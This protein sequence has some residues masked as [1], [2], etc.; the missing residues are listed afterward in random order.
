MK[1]KVKDIEA[2]PYRD[3]DSYAIDRERIEGLKDSIGKDEFWGG[4]PI[5]PHPTKQGKYQTGCGHHRLLS[6]KEN[7]VT[8]IEIT[9]V[10]PYTDSQMLR[11]MVNEN[12]EYAARPK[13]VNSDIERVKNKLQQWVDQYDTWEK[14]R[15]DKNIITVFSSQEQWAVPKGRGIGRKTILAYLG[16]PWAR[17]EWMIQA[18][19]ATLKAEKDGTVDR[20][21][22]ETI[23]TIDQANVFRAAV[24][25]HKL[26]KPT[27]KRVA[28][29]ITK[30]QI[31]SKQIPALVAEHSPM[32]TEKKPIKA[33]PL[34]MLDDY[35]RNAANRAAQLSTDLRH[36]KRGI[37]NIQSVHVANLL[38]TRLKDLKTV[39]ED[40][41]SLLETS[42]EKA[43]RAIP[44]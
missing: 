3:F 39:M 2:N 14:A 10:H 34:P 31:P 24:Q 38:R 8:E 4:I 18:A 19:L 42:N 12:A 9:A 44:V 30:E 25:K 35:V 1:V 7:G 22:V 37:N 16:K 36:I 41:L 20:V 23:P 21:A 32:S 28:Q 5:R 43:K 13:L 26:P 40:V 6:L 17:R 11:I 27:Q 29:K 33:K 15:S